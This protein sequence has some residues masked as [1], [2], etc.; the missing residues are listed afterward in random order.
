VQTHC[1]GEMETFTPPCGKYIQDNTCKT[2][3]ESAGF[4]R[5]CHKNI[6]VCFFVS[7]FQVLFT[8]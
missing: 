5:W 3:S 6:L 4:C 8:Y 7:Q 1:L 2:L